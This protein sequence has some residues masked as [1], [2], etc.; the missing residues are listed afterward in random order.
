MGPKCLHDEV[1]GHLTILIQRA[2][3]ERGEASPSTIGV[4]MRLQARQSRTTERGEAISRGSEA[5]HDRIA[6]NSCHV[7]R[8]ASG[9][10]CVVGA[11]T[12][13]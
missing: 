5:A 10:H 1:M 8:F 6:I 3:V 4:P 13:T 2:P 11:N 12:R 9:A 7:A